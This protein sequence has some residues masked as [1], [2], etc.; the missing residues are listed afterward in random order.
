MSVQARAEILQETGEA[1]W[2]ACEV[3]M[4]RLNKTPPSCATTSNR[5]F[6]DVTASHACF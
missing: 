1:T 4:S 3:T 2:G 6:P 5:R